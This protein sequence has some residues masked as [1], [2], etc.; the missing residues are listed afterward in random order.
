MIRYEIPVRAVSEANLRECW[1][2]R[3]RRAKAQREVAYYHTVNE[4]AC[5]HNRPRLP[6]A[7]TLTRIGKRRL[8]SDN[9]ARSLKAVR[10]G[11]ADA[12][13]VDDG[14]ERIEWRYAQRVGKDY[15]VEVEI[16]SAT[17]NT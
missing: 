13:G 14:D 17:V 2:A 3:R 16:E 7:I 15:A 10:D 1:Q 6:M 11:I 9:L 12:L 5:A 4:M 8:D